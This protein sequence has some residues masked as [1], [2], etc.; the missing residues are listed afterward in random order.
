MCSVVCLAC[1]DCSFSFHPAPLWITARCAPPPI[2][3]SQPITVSFYQSL[4]G[5]PSLARSRLMGVPCLIGCS[6]RPSFPSLPPLSSEPQRLRLGI[7]PHWRQAPWPG[8]RAGTRR[9]CATGALALTTLAVPPEHLQPNNSAAIPVPNG[10]VPAVSRGKPIL[11]RCSCQ[12]T[13]A[14]RRAWPCSPRCPRK[15]V[16]QSRVSPTCG[17]ESVRSGSIIF[18]VM[19]GVHNVPGS[20]QGAS[21]P[22]GNEQRRL[23]PGVGRSWRGRGPL[24]R[25]LDWPCLYRGLD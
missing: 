24:F 10:P 15:R 17:A 1:V 9:T 12:T 2:L 19:V 22:W 14:R 7:T 21:K 20:Q 23:P 3:I 16:V 13:F 6:S 5:S 4:T 11:T 18:W 25:S 8:A